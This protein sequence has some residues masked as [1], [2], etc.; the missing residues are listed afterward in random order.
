MKTDKNI[1]FSPAL[2]SLHCTNCVQKIAPVIFCNTVFG[3]STVCGQADNH[4][5]RSLSDLMVGFGG[6]DGIFC[7]NGYGAP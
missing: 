3:L 5:C 7:S 1:H 4:V 2:P 6:G